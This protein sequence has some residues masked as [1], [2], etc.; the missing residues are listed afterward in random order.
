MKNNIFT[1]ILASLLLLPAAASALKPVETVLEITGSVGTVSMSPYTPAVDV[2][3]ATS[4]SYSGYYGSSNYSQSPDS[5]YFNTGMDAYIAMYL[6][7]DEPLYIIAPY[8]RFGTCSTGKDIK[9][10]P[11]DN[12]SD[13]SVYQDRKDNFDMSFAGV[14]VR[15]YFID[16]PLPI[17]LYFG[18]DIGYFSTLFMG[19]K[20]QILNYTNPDDKA[21][22]LVEKNTINRYSGGFFG[23]HLETGADYWINNTV[24][25]TAKIGLR[26]GSGG[27]NGVLNS[28]DKY[29]NPTAAD[30]TTV[31]QQVNLSGMYFSTG[32]ILSFGRK[33][34]GKPPAI[35]EKEAPP[36]ALP[37]VTQAMEKGDA[38]YSIG[39]YKAA[40]KSYD[41]ALFYTQNPVIYK[42]IANCLFNMGQIKDAK[43]L[44]EISLK[45][46]PDDGALR[47]WLDMQK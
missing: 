43:R 36:E 4:N 27:I 14:G 6:L 32:I 10:A 20:S 46:E 25:L 22:S 40:L 1:A 23:V 7:N 8:I 2:L 31:I 24:G 18:A 17:N 47:S 35:A 19:P 45:M 41:T 5:I 3:S 11:Y 13:E 37:L 12:Y 33:N 38:E 16:S 15:R 21:G 34:S 39:D 29:N 28:T 30:N 26:E 44:Y 9:G 42:K